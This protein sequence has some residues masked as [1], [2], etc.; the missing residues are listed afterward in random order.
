VNRGL[1]LQY[2][3]FLQDFIDG[4][5]ALFTLRLHSLSHMETARAELET[6]A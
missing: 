1:S 2:K 5:R 4:V 3:G 6:V